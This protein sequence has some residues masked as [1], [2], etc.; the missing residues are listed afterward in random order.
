MSVCSIGVGRQARL[1]VSLLLGLS[2]LSVSLASVSRAAS[3][4]PPSVG[5]PQHP[6]ISPTGR[7][8]VFSSAGDLWAV[9]AEGGPATR[10]TSHP[11]LELRSAFSP[12]GS[13]L[14]F[15]SNRDGARNLYVMPIIREDGRVIAGEIERV[16]VSGRS[17]TLGGFTA[18]GDELLYHAREEPS[19]YR[20]ARMYRA[21][22][23]GGPVERVTDAFGWHPVMSA[24]AE[25]FVFQRG[26]SLWERPVYRGPGTKDIWSMST[27][28]GSFTRLT[29][30]EANDG[31]AFP[32]PD[33]SVVFVSSRDGQNNVYRLEADASDGG[34]RRP[35]ALAQLTEFE[36]SRRELTLAHGVR[37]FSV[38][39]SG[40]RAVFRVWDD[41]YTL[42]LLE[43][44]AEPRRLEVY[45]S[46][47][48]DRQDT[49]RLDLDRRVSEAAMS[50]DGKAVAV[51]ARG[52]VFVRSTAEDHPTRRVT[53]T[54][55][56]E[57]GLAWAPDGSALYFASDATGD[58]DIHRATVT[59]SREDIEPE[60]G[61]EQADSEEGQE[62]GQGHQA[63]TPDEPAAE[64][65]DDGLSG[66]WSCVARGPA[67]LPAE[68]LPF[69]LELAL[70]EGAV[71]GRLSAPGMYEGEIE[72]ATY[73]ER[74][75]TL[76]FSVTL[77]DGTGVRFSLVVIDGTLVGGAVA[78]GQSYEVEGERTARPRPAEPEEADADA[79]GEEQE[80]KV[81]YGK[82]WAEALRFEVEPLVTGETNDVD[83]VPSPDGRR[84]LFRRGRG[85]LVAL[86]LAS[87][88]QRTVL[89]GWDAPT[90]EW[91]GDSRHIIYSREDLYFNSDVWLLDAF[92]PDAEPINLTRHPDYDT[93]PRLSA[94]G[95][96][97]AFLS[98]RAGN[99][100]DFDVYRVYLDKSL[101]GLADYE[102][103]E[104]FKRAVR[105]AKKR[106]PIDPVSRGA[107]AE[108]DDANGSEAAVDGAGTDGGVPEP[109][110]FDAGDAY[111][112]V[113]RI[114]STE[115][116][117]GDLAITPAG[118][119][120]LFEGSIDGRRAFY[121]VDHRGRARKVVR[122]GGV[123]DPRVSL[124][125]S[126]VSFV[127][128]GQARS[129][130]PT[131]GGSK[132]YPIDAT[133]VVEIEA[134]QRQKFLEATR[135][136]GQ[137]FYHPTLKGLDWEGLTE[138]YLQLAART[139]TSQAFNRVVGDLFGELDG[140]HLGIFG[141]GGFS[142]EGPGIG[143]L[144]VE[145]TPVGGGYRVESVLADSPAAAEQ[146]R[147]RV[148]D[149]I[150]A[151]DERRV[152][153]NEES[154][155]TVDLDAAMAG[156]AGRE[157][158]LE[159]VRAPAA[160]PR[161]GAAEDVEGADAEE[162]HETA[163]PGSA[164]VLIEPVSY[165]RLSN[166]AYEAEV[167]RR[168]ARVEALSDGRL[169]YLHIRGM[170]M[171]S[172]RDF[173]RD[174]YAAAHG[175]DGLIIDVRDNGGGF[176]TDI[177]LSS[178]T[179]PRHAY[180]VPRGAE[181]EDARPDAYPRDRRLIY[182][183]QRP[184]SVVINQ[185]SFSNAEIFSHAIK[186]IGRGKLVGTQTF[187]GVISTG[188]VRL[189]DGTFVRRPFRG[190]FLPDGTD[191]EHNG[192]VPDI[193][194][195]Q[196]PASEVGGRDPQL[197]AAVHE[198]L[199]RVEASPDGLWHPGE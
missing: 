192:A 63:A 43:E 132:G 123:S 149:V 89:V 39:W 100:W 18:G 167:R 68:G 27:D 173:E 40:T 93:M 14:A 117:A 25:R 125:G 193:P 148:G 180:T 174:L 185:H 98:D 195:A 4:A 158:L 190:W 67:P 188:G 37:D 97:L 65:E 120:V 147:L 129:A 64:P 80:P 137:D 156:T 5:Y 145:A 13:M 134:Q 130:S 140:S 155:P 162:E 101:E 95:K 53:R 94:D 169:G 187:G 153:P 96:V 70:E 72:D 45:V 115:G 3:P 179:A 166:L 23:G 113:R 197:E 139:R 82:R 29:S 71:T 91:V 103:A 133:V 46:A 111:L 163:K 6:T 87:G 138:R 104:R 164:Y 127:S 33:G 175:K 84:V 136:L 102:L 107:G 108:G 49:E 150:V 121:S 1:G 194:V 51:I 182:Q 154:M 118:D 66:T 168:R 44:D 181:E 142:T 160:N 198:L 159:I 73:N 8:V 152:A 135:T 55:A 165:G 50:P 62:A 191:M 189:I 10:L 60:E 186:T 42:D 109:Y 144:G 12:D 52:E 81:D 35:R 74:M 176:T 105:Q 110:E 106:T 83:P 112:R 69:T 75:R 48:T 177:L 26:Y 131:G 86:D 172:V 15:E 31:S 57:R 20:Q 61:A 88:E 16:T 99:N 58:W 90:V 92:D 196:T 170:N 24:D 54:H 146:S 151:V 22:L 30:F 119:R 79:E 161:E 171:P 9:D 7:L 11:A 19:I 2:L 178:L 143:H 124:T 114:A 78:A 77:E 157:T 38:S 183:Y 59:L 128:G 141:G 41:L 199:E 21:P 76:S 116:G 56:R 126:T 184:I 17:Q 34:R 32:M 47:D 85:D 36:P 28:D 122:N